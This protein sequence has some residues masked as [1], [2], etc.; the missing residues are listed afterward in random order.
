M[1]RGKKDQAR[2]CPCGC[3]EELA[4][5]SHFR[6]GRDGRVKG[7]FVKVDKGQMKLDELTPAEQSIYPFITNG[8][9]RTLREAAAKVESA[10]KTRVKP[11]AA[12]E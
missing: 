6:M 2:Y 11:K 12:A 8:K 1:K 5:G 10:S 3:G 7:R 4:S 9:V